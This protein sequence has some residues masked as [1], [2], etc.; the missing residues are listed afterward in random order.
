[1]TT[2]LHVGSITS[3]GAVHAGDNPEADILF[4]KRKPSEPQEGRVTKAGTAVP[5]IDLTALDDAT[6][7][8][9]QE[10]EAKLASNEEEVAPPLPDDLPDVVK[11]RLDAQD[12]ALAKERERNE[13]L[14]D[15]LAKMRE[16]RAI[17]KYTKMAES[18]RDLMGD[19]AETAPMF[20]DLAEHAPDQFD[21]L[22]AKIENV[23]TIAGFDALL[24]EHGDSGAEGSALDQITAHAAEIKK[25]QPDLSLAEAR[26]EAWKAHPELKEQ[27]REEGVR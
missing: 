27:A 3:I 15:D 8:Y 17:E 5:D 26:V 18:V 25:N 21:A 10:L 7:G 13:A 6:R 20:K 14:A 22:Y 24:K 23:K 11:S 19:P 4:W 12:E 16:E 9:I 1:M 2:R